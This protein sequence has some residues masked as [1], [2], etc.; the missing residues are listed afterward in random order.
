MALEHTGQSHFYR[1][2]EC[3]G[4]FDLKHNDHQ[5]ETRDEAIERADAYAEALREIIET[6]ESTD[7]KT[8]ADEALVQIIR[9]AKAA[10][11]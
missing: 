8:F 4:T 10:T 7:R 3:G 11:E 5:C 1:C 2:T 9:I 6:A